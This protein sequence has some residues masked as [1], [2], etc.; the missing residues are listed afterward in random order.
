MASRPKK[1]L[2]E[3]LLCEPDGYAGN[4]E[5]KSPPTQTVHHWSLT[6]MLERAETLR[7]IAR[8]GHGSAT[9]P[10]TKYPRH[11]TMLTFRGHDG[12]AELHDDFADLYLVLDGH[13]TMVTGG[14]LIGGLPIDEG[15][16]RGLHIEDGL[17][18]ELRVGDVVHVPAGV[19]H[20]ILVG[21]DRTV[22]C[23][24]VRSKETA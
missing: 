4:P 14:V 9:E 6:L 24:V 20:Q 18:R 8:Y 22:T 10:V 11:C 19:P 21:A 17:S 16:Y 3:P 12:V 1:I 13:A 5:R 7:R 23:F 15:E 2:D